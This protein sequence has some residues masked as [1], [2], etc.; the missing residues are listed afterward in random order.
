[1]KVAGDSATRRLGGS[2]TWWPK[3][4]PPHPSSTSHP[5]PSTVGCFVSAKLF[6]QQ[7]P[8]LFVDKPDCRVPWKLPGVF[9]L[10]LLLRLVLEQSAYVVH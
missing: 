2:V 3:V 8:R 7:F 6:M 5:L 9:L 4:H 10:L 1:M